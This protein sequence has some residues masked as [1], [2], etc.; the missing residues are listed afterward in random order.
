MEI[1]VTDS[2]MAGRCH[3]VQATCN[4]HVTELA[5]LRIYS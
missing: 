2:Y 1:Y 4:S 3:A 5:Q